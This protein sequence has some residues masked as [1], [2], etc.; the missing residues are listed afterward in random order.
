MQDIRRIAHVA[1]ELRRTL[2]RTGHDTGQLSRQTANQKVKTFVAKPT[3]SR[4]SEMCRPTDAISCS[5]TLRTTPTDC[6]PCQFLENTP[7]I[8]AAGF[9]IILIQMNDTERHRKRKTTTSDPNNSCRM[10]TRPPNCFKSERVRDA[11]AYSYA[12]CLHAALT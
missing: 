1:E 8:L 2:A 10:R 4:I 11:R 3:A 6:R 12:K 5:Y 7:L 9:Y